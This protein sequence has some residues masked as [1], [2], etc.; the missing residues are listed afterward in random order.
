[1]KKVVQNGDKAKRL[2]KK[3]K[4][5]ES[6]FILEEEPKKPRK[7]KLAKN[8]YS[9]QEIRPLTNNQATSFEEYERGQH[10]ML[11]GSAGTGK[12]FLAMF[13]ALHSMQNENKKKIYIVRSAVAVRDLGFMPGSLADKISLYEPVY[14][15]ITR[16]LTG[17][18]DLYDKLKEEDML[19]FI[20]TSYLRG[21]TIDNSIIIVD[22][23]SN[24]TF[25]ELDSIITRVGFDTRI[26]FSGDFE[27]TD[28]KNKSEKQGVLDFM[29]I[30]GKM[31]SFSIINFEID[32]IVRSG[33]V[34]EYLLTKHHSSK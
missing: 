4:T 23:F 26:I 9:V 10:L 34:K 19:E 32:D 16:E 25:H 2:R 18:P 3:I 13:F 5:K 33:I 1:M 7:Q 29:Y 6:E 12:S 20:S 15:N 11:S 21:L 28:L 27:Q 22:E 17:K 8:L 24:L 14:K 30:I 31:K